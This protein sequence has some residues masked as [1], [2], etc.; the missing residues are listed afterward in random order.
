MSKPYNTGIE[1][2]PKELR[3]EY[4]EILNQQLYIVD[5]YM[6]EVLEIRPGTYQHFEYQFKIRHPEWEQKKR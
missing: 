4:T 3:K 2:F 1:K 5:P 6:T